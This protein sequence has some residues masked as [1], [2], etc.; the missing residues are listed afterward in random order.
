MLERDLLLRA[1]LDER[2][3]AARTRLGPALPQPFSD[4]APADPEESL[5]VFMVRLWP[6]VGRGTA[7]LED[8]SHFFDRLAELGQP[9]H[10]A[11]LRFLDAWNNAYEVAADDF[12]QVFVAAYV[13]LLEAHVRRLSPERRPGDG[14]QSVVQL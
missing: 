3:Q 2:L 4:A 7:T 5:R 14:K 12:P 13:E 9:A 10:S 6:R 1:A 8:R 11:D